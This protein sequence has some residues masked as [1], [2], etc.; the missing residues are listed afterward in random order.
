MKSSFFYPVDRSQAYTVI[1]INMMAGRKPE[2]IKKLIKTLFTQIERN[3][4]IAPIDIEITFKEQPDYCW[5][6]RGMIGD[7]AKD[8]SYSVKV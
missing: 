3:I 2:T 1:K 6:F 5:G 7:E 8:L 4:G